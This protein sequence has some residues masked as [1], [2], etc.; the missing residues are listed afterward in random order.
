[1]KSILILIPTFAIALFAGE[2]SALAQQY[3]GPPRNAHGYSEV[4]E[5]IEQRG[6]YDGMKGAERD[7]RNHRQPNVNN[8][9]EYRDP[10][11]VPGWA[12][13]EYREGFR[14]GYYRMVRQIYR[15]EGVDRYGYYSP[16]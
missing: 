6:Y 5:A 1:M 12:R 9:E 11:S 13:H 3:Y 8:R 16:R 14:R 4:E 7:F 15:A 10:D 2:K